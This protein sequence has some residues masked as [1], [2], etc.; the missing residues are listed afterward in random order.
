MYFWKSRFD[1]R[2]LNSEIKAKYHKQFLFQYEICLNIDSDKSKSDLT[3][4]LL[5]NSGLSLF[6]TD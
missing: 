4:K 2:I 6:R 5:T 3:Y 1:L